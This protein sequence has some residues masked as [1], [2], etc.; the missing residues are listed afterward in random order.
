MPHPSRRSMLAGLAVA[1]LLLRRAAA[2]PVEV[3][4]VG[5]GVAGLAA[6]MELA[7]RRIGFR[8]LEARSRIGG[9]AWT[10]SRSLGVPFDRG[11]TWLE[12]AGH[13]PFVTILRGRGHRLL[14][15]GPERLWLDGRWAGGAE[16]AALAAAQDRLDRVIA[17]AGRAGRDVAVGVLWET[18]DRFAR[19]AG[20]IAGP[21]EAGVELDRLSALEVWNQPGGGEFLVEGGLGAALAGWGAAVPVELDTAV[22]RIA[23]I[24]GGVRVETDR[25][26]LEAAAA[27]VT[28]SPGVLAAGGL[29][30]EPPLAEPW[31]SAIRNV[32]M[33]G[34]EKIALAFDR[35]VLG[36]ASSWTLY[37]QEG[38]AGEPFTFLVRPFGQEVAI[39]FVG[40][41]LSAELL[42]AGEGAAIA[43]A[44]DRLA[45][46]L[47]TTVRS[48]FARGTA[49]RWQI[50]PWTRGA[51]SAAIPGHWADRAR[52]AEPIDGRI[53][54]AGEATEPELCTVV[55]GALASGRRAARQ[56]ARLVRG[57]R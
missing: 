35:P 11:C 44:L 2:A 14:R 16:R 19:I 52:L 17:A 53:F 51:Y 23:S 54:L 1:P 33:G 24:R 20:A 28:A 15:E 42:G 31:A 4:V 9:R 8:L 39:A 13:N 3:V 41:A 57:R 30:F 36:R 18:T 55:Q 25:G 40:G 46:V 47:G 48:G 43:W 29:R 12:A 50:D 34:F 22:T 45:A 7:R 6:A 21:L 26:A 5:A 10:E 27:I 56:V 49:T 38:P 37:G 32:A